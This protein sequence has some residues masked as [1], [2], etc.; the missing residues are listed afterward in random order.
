[1]VVVVVET[2]AAVQGRVLKT[3]I[4]AGKGMATYHIVLDRHMLTTRHHFIHSIEFSE[5]SKRYE[6]KPSQTKTVRRGSARAQ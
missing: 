4:R 5:L 3:A 6:T 2:I 1:V